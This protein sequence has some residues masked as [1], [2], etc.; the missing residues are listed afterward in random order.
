MV[1][2][3]G[4]LTMFLQN[5]SSFILDENFYFN[6]FMPFITE[7]KDNE[8]KI[9]YLK[10]KTNEVLFRN[11]NN[12]DELIIVLSGNGG[13]TVN[14]EGSLIKTG[15]LIHLYKNTIYSIANIK[16]EELHVVFITIC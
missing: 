7:G 3:I 11:T 12:N 15:D 4:G 13:I 5:Q 14:G 6:H 8:W 9:K 16:K 2:I 1:N 10:I